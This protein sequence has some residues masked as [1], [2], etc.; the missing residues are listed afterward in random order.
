MAGSSLKGKTIRGVAWN[1]VNTVG[2]LCIHFVVS[3]LLARMLMP[4][5]Y[6]AV[7]M[8]GVFTSV[9]QIFTDGGLTAA[10]IRTEDRTEEDK[11]TIFYYNFVACYIIYG[12]IF[13]IAPFIAS[14]YHMPILC[15]LARVSSLGMLISPLASMQ[16]VHFT[17]NLDFKTPAMISI[18]CTAVTAALSLWMAYHGFGVW[19]LAVPGVFTTV[20][21][22]ALLIGIVRWRPTKGFSMTAF[23]QLFG[24]SSKL[25][26]SQLLNKA[27]NNIT[28]LIV[29]RFFSPAQLGIYERAKGWPALPSQTFTGVLQGVTFPVLSK[30]QDDIS[31]MRRNYRRMLK[32]S[33]Y[34]VFPMMVGLAS[35]ARPLT[36]VLITEKW[37][38]SVPLMQL[39]CFSMMWYPIH[40]INLNLLTVTGRSDYFLR[41]EIIKKVW[42]LAVMFCS[43]PF[44]LTAFCAAGIVSSYVCLFI[45]TYYTKKI[46][47]LGVWQQMKD[48]LPVLANSMA[49]GL[50]S[51]AVQMPFDNNGAKIA[52]AIPA[53]IIYYIATTRYL[54]T[55]EYNE[56][57]GII[58]AKV[59]IFNRLKRL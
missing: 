29:G 30:M 39:I 22:V 21:R 31:R 37:I 13:L 56:M 23:R 14:F 27:Y 57:I 58:G 44:G 45:N 12:V 1:S 3:I 42:G 53:A 43:L 8:V 47:D 28:P 16:G 41:L 49:M 6:G 55:E 54:Q 48:L 26:A 34:L 40:A 52:V 4:D 18:V 10:I 50:V 46:I 36:V 7:A 9:L 25:L 59:P 19:A 38:A 32:L 2:N 15:K 33:A 51:L 17:I 20:L 24:Y 35:L 11:C 5:D